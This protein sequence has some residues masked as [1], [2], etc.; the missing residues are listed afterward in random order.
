MTMTKL[1][2]ALTGAI[3]VTAAAAPLAI[4]QHHQLRSL[5]DANEVLRQQLAGLKTDTE[6]VPAAAPGTPSSEPS[7]ELLRLRSEVT[8][9]RA[10]AQSAGQNNGVVDPSATHSLDAEFQVLQA[11][12]TLLKQKLEESPAEKIPEEDLLTP[13][14][15]LNV[16]L[17]ADLRNDGGIRYNL[18]QLRSAAKDQFA[19]MLAAALRSYVD[20]NNGQLPA[21]LAQLKSCLPPTVSDAMLDRYDLL[22]TGNVIDLPSGT[23]I[24]GEKPTKDRMVDS[25]Y[26][27]GLDRYQVKTVT[28]VVNGRGMRIG[29]SD[30]EMTKFIPGIQLR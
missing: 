27:I 6:P 9:L 19:P 22:H 24:V 3:V 1:Q 25:L 23:P 14:D 4:H 12:I 20:A 2:A 11:R 16:A 8:R 10:A 15:W 7:G 28:Q 26:S 30:M 18:N 21:S 29:G 13:H 5:A 17:T